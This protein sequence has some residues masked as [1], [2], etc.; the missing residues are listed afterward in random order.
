L[1]QLAPAPWRGVL[2]RRRPTMSLR[3]AESSQRGLPPAFPMPL[4]AGGDDVYSLFSRLGLRSV[5]NDTPRNADPDRQLRESQ[6]VLVALLCHRCG[7]DLGAEIGPMLGK[8]PG[9]PAG[10]LASCGTCGSTTFAPVPESVD[11]T[12]G[13]EKSKPSGLFAARDKHRASR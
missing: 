9:V 4:Q 8:G 6:T 3:D 10:T 5:V 2:S 7:R 13:D 1:G 12:D 11:S